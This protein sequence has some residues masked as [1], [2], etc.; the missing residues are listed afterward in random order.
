MH[1]PSWPRRGKP[2][3]EAD[4]ARTGRE[5]RHPSPTTDVKTAALRTLCQ[6]SGRR[7]G[8]GGMPLLLGRCHST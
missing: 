4:A 1:L 7:A 2:L 5:W 6:V 3:R 8:R